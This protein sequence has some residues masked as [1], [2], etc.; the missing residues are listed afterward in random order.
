MAMEHNVVRFKGTL[1]GGE[2]WSINP[3]FWDSV[4]PFEDSPASYADLLA[5]ATDIA[6]LNGGNIFPDSVQAVMSSETK[7]TLIRTEYWK[8]NVMEMAAELAP[9]FPV[10]GAGSVTKPLQT[11]LVASL[12]TGKPGR[13]YRGR[14]YF[15]ALG[16]DIDGSTGRLSTA[17]I[18]GLSEDIGQWLHDVGQAGSFV[19]R[20][21]AAPCVVSKRQNVINRVLTVAVGD[22][23]DSQR[24]RRDGLVEAYALGDVPSIL[25]T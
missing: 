16:A 17:V 4:G 5:W 13:S 20:T 25:P 22:V 2:N 21:L 19:L 15:P 9:P 1:P 6:A 18:E 24:R 14:I 3:S 8:D 7:T 11:A 10:F 23:L 12:R